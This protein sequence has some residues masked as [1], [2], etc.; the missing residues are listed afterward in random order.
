MNAKT[1][2]VLVGA[3]FSVCTKH[4]LFVLVMAGNTHIAVVVA[5]LY[6]HFYKQHLDCEHKL[7]LD[8]FNKKELKKI[9][10]ICLL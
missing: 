4:Y 9:V 8:L 2:L 3:R 6:E 5:T 7:H 10:F 1:N